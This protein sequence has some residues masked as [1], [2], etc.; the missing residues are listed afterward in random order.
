MW[1]WDQEELFVSLS[2]VKT[3]ISNIYSN[4]KVHRRME[5]V[6][7]AKELDRNSIDENAYQSTTTDRLRCGEARAKKQH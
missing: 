7:K 3:H 6:T 5:A 1:S 4:L 2:T